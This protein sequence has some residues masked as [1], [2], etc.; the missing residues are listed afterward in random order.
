M[1]VGAEEDKGDEVGE[2]YIRNKAEE[3]DKVDEGEY[4][5]TMKIRKRTKETKGAR[6]GQR[7]QRRRSRRE[8]K[9]DEGDKGDNTTEEGYE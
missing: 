3:W 6:T 4:R 2:R 7:V 9:G 1:D 5:R 8:D